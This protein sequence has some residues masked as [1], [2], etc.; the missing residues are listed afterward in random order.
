MVST[1]ANITESIMEIMESKSNKEQKSVE[2]PAKKIVF[3]VSFIGL[4]VCVIWLI[5][6]LY[7]NNRAEQDMEALRESNVQEEPPLPEDLAMPIESTVASENADMSEGTEPESLYPGLDG[8]NVPEKNIDFEAQR[9]E[10]NEHIYAWITI[11]GTVIDYPIVQ[12]PEDPDY[13]LEYNLDHTKGRPGGIFTQ[14]YNSMDWED[15]NTVIYGHNMRVGTMFAGLHQYEDPQFFEEYPYVYI[16]SEDK[17]RVY[18]VF[19][20]YE[21][22]DINLVM[23]FNMPGVMSYEEYLASIYGL[24]GMNNNFNTDITVTAEDKIITL[25]T[26]VR[27]NEERRYLVQAVLVAEGEL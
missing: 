6:Y 16:Y 3:V 26:C 13:Y 19:A 2:S 25:S 11:P 20:A 5:R 24:D 17:T 10:V 15:A 8:F 14:F 18:E 27:G 22:D 9:S 12:H 21:Y 1:T 4:I 7:Q 23:Y